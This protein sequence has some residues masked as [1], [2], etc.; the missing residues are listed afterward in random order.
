MS[1]LRSLDVRGLDH[2]QKEGNGTSLEA[3]CPLLGI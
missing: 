2:H 3:V 1:T